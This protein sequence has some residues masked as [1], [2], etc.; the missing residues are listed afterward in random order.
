[1]DAI[2]AVTQT[3][4]AEPAV[5]LERRVFGARVTR[6]TGVSTLI[7]ASLLAACTP[8]TPPA[9]SSTSE[10]RAARDAG[11]LDASDASS[12]AATDAGNTKADAGDDDG[13]K[14]DAGK[15]QRRDAGVRRED[16]SDIPDAAR[17]EQAPDAASDAESP[18]AADS[19]PDADAAPPG[20]R[21]SC[22]QEESACICVESDS[23]EDT[24]ALPK[25]SCCFTLVTGGRV[26][27]ACWPPTS[28]ACRDYRN[29]AQAPN[30]IGSCPPP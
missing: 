8:V 27:C 30:L 29:E 11:T 10:Q 18:N 7:V 28:Q 15:P 21:W 14:R 20:R 16:A 13:H 3:R 1:M 5:A 25:P 24:C 9:V 22:R 12:E 6:L 2:H 19:G 26:S 17:R 23:A 4:C